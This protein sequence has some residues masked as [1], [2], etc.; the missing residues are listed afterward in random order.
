MSQDNIIDL[1]GRGEISDPL[2]ALLRS[3]ARQLIC[4]AVRAEL[5]GFM[6]GY[7]GQKTSRG[8]AAVVRN[9]HKIKPVWCLS[10]LLLTVIMIGKKI[11]F[12]THR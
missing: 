9:A 1:T 11:E 6:T 5:E 7:A 4:Q 8:H 3:G 2:T 10:I 12:S